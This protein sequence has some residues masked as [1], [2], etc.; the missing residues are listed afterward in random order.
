MHLILLESVEV[1]EF[2]ATV[3]YV[4]LGLTNVVH[5]IRKLFREETEKFAIWI[6]PN[7]LID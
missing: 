6:K 1:M 2:H 4:N 3:A 5:S 7:N